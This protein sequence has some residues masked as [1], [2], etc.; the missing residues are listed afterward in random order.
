[1]NARS[2]SL[3]SAS[4]AQTVRSP[5]M[6]RLLRPTN[7]TQAMMAGL[8]MEKLEVDNGEEGGSRQNQECVMNRRPDAE[9]NNEHAG[10]RASAKNAEI[11]ASV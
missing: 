7:D 10:A 2:I 8:E 1:M 5:K 4:A 11:N 6:N 9:L 3:R